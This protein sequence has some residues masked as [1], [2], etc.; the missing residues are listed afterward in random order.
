VVLGFLELPE[1]EKPPEEIW[2]HMERLTEWF[3]AV[4]ERRRNPDMEPIGEYKGDVP[5]M[6]NEYLEE[7]MG[8]ANGSSE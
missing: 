6:R 3:D 8:G 4:K 7:V 1:D 2:H 5:L